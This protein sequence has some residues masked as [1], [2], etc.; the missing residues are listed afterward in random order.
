MQSLFWVSVMVYFAFPN[1]V[2]HALDSTNY[3]S[4]ASFFSACELYNKQHARQQATK[5]YQNVWIHIKK[6]WPDKKKIRPI[7]SKKIQSRSVYALGHTHL[8]VCKKAFRFT[9]KQVGHNTNSHGL[10]VKRLYIYVIFT[11]TLHDFDRQTSTLS[12]R[13]CVNMEEQTHVHRASARVK[14]WN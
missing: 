7:K 3:L 2:D 8:Y 12:P 10:H 14:V 4:C 6:N 5:T 11:E 9:T 13:M 1:A